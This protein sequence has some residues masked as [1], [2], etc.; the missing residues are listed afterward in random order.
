MDENNIYEL[1]IY[2]FYCQKYI[3]GYGFHWE[4]KCHSLKNN[5]NKVN[6]SDTDCFYIQTLVKLKESFSYIKLIN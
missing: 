2:Q 1:I 3:V 4:K 6:L 5:N